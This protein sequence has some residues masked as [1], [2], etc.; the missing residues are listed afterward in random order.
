[1]SIF[2]I[3]AAE[4]FGALDWDAMA[5]GVQVDA[6]ACRTIG[7][8]AN[9]LLKKRHQILSLVWPITASTV[10]DVSQR[11]MEMV[12]DGAWGLVL[13]PQMMLKKPQITSATLYL[14]AL[15][16][17]TRTVRVRVGTRASDAE[18]AQEFDLAGTGSFAYYSTSIAL[19]PGEQEELRLYARTD[20]TAAL[21]DTGTYGT[22]NSGT[23]GTTGVVNID[24]FVLP[25]GSHTID[26][27]A[28]IAGH[29]LRYLRG[30][31]PVTTVLAEERITGVVT[32]GSDHVIQHEPMSPEQLAAVR[33][34]AAVTT[35]EIRQLTSLTLA[36]V[37]VVTEDR[38]F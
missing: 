21:M 32:P 4:S 13:P 6:N 1:M 36:Q 18:G 10:D 27:D 30:G 2:S 7:R 14:R 31:F 37:L 28:A 33:L 23:V 11:H 24:H 12:P 17:N 3:E 15:V 16:P 8:Q 29:V 38:S 25:S 26:Q 34:N 35:F 5:D 22:P 19:D 20:D 9:R